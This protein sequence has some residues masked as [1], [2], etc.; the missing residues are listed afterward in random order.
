MADKKVLTVDNINPHIR[1]MEYAV[2]GRL[3]IRAEEIRDELAQ[4]RKFPFNTV[5]S[6]NIGN[7]QQLNQ[8]PITFFRQVAS[9]CEN[10]DLL[11]ADKE[12]IVSQLYP[13]DAIDR[14][15]QILKD[16]G[17]G[18]GAYSHSQG[19]PALRKAVASFI[20]ERD[21]HPADPNSIYL[22][23]GASAGVQN[24]LSILTENEKTGILIPIP[25]YPL[26]SATL[27]LLGATPVPYYL[28]E[29]SGWSLDVE[30]IRKTV[31]EARSKGT[32]VRALVIINPGN[33][34]GQCLDA[35]NMQDILTFCHTERL[36]L[37]ADEVYQTNIYEPE[38]RPFVSFKKA[39]KE[40]PERDAIELV[41][42]HSISKG[43]IGEC[44]RRG[45]YFECCN[46]DS[47]VMAQLYKMAS[48]SLCPNV[49]G[50][51]MTALM[52]TPPKQGEPS[53][54]LYQ[55]EMTGLYE[56]LRRRSKKLEAVFNDMEGVTC[57]PAMGSMYL[58]PRIR[59]P[60]K[61]IA[62]AAELKVLPDAFYADQML[63]ATG[64]CVVPGSGFAQKE[65]TWH[66]RST[67]LPPE[68]LFDDFCGNL[69]KFHAD[70]MATYN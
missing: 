54:A 6:C 47:G 65:G 43:M 55:N 39:L 60:P 36:V 20:A 15:R 40:H 68:E 31:H 3:A 16:I 63:E 21:G 18:I 56:S 7:P 9:L 42:F 69:R 24:I 57:Q 50:Q 26:Y 25:Q 34:T 64:V 58:F 49:S 5:V 10:P 32:D 17:A 53:Y 44:G 45:G 62:K 51:I 14:A 13:K 1:D 30:E 12:P 48:V 23:Q 61:A 35:Q 28:D 33:P 2:R 66:F 19:V 29:D 46:L 41:S 52:V 59:L 11:T 22:T 4:G 70:F 37:L 38:Q 67:F 27:T 8:K